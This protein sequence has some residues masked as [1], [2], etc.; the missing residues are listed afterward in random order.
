MRRKCVQAFT[1]MEL[2]TIIS[3]VVTLILVAIPSANWIRYKTKESA[4]L[5]NLRQLGM[6][7]SL[8][9]TSNDGRLPFAFIEYSESK[10]VSWDRLISSSG[11]SGSNIRNLLRC[12]SDTIPANGAAP[13]RTYA[14]PK[15][16]MDQWNWPPAPG[17]ATGVG[18]WWSPRGRWHA[19]LANVNSSNSVPS[20]RADLISAPAMTALLT[21]QAQRYNVEFSYAGAAIDG[22]ASHLDTKILTAS[23]YHGGKFN[24]LMVDGHVRLLSPLESLGESDP[25]F[26]DPTARFEN[27]W[28]IK[29]Q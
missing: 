4:C 20:M 16:S 23:Q 21:E 17:N 9:E 26:D 1:F 10:F 28:T 5:A 19:A 14:M 22:P 15:H 11:S 18:L 2:A 29:H 3:V 27:V 24:Y 12:P 7:M 25:M 13:R 6:A 8:Y